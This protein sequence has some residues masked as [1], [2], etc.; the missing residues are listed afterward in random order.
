MINIYKNMAKK[1]LVKIKR[2]NTVVEQ[3]TFL[4]KNFKS[5]LEIVFYI[6]LMFYIG[7]DEIFKTFNLLKVKNDIETD[8]ANVKNEI[9]VDLTDASK[10]VIQLSKEVSINYLEIGIVVILLSIVIYKIIGLFKKK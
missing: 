4:L 6:F 8:I 7:F 2:I 9:E 10:E 5:L 3:L 1:I